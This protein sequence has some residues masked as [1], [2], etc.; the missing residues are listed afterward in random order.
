[1]AFS[2]PGGQRHIDA[3]DRTNGQLIGVDDDFG[4]S[5]AGAAKKQAEIARQG[6]EQAESGNSAAQH[7]MQIGLAQAQTAGAQ[8]AV[9]RGSNPLAQ[10]AAMY[11]SSQMANQANAQSGL[12]RAQE[13][14]NARN[15]YMGAMGQQAQGE[16]GY[17]Q[18]G[19]QQQIAQAK[20]D[21]NWQK[22]Q[23]DEEERER[24][25][26]MQM[27]GTAMSMAGMA[28]MS[29]ERT[30]NILS[31]NDGFPSELTKLEQGGRPLGSPYSDAPP[32]KKGG[33]TTGAYGSTDWA[34]FAERGQSRELP[35]N[36]FASGDVAAHTM[37]R[38]AEGQQAA[39]RGM[40][41]G[42]WSPG[43]AQE[44]YEAF[45]TPASRGAGLDAEFSG[46]GSYRV[47]D[48]VVI[49][50]PKMGR[51][52]DVGGE[53]VTPTTG[54]R[55]WAPMPA[56]SV[57][58]VGLDNAGL[59][60]STAAMAADMPEAPR[61]QIKRQNMGGIGQGFASEGATAGDMGGRGGG[62]MDAGSMAGIAGSLSDKRA[63]RLLAENQALKAQLPER[64]SS[65]TSM[66]NTPTPR[67]PERSS[68]TSEMPARHAP[69][70]P[71]GPL[72]GGQPNYSGTF[73][74]ENQWRAQHP[75]EA[76]EMDL[77]GQPAPR[78]FTGGRP[79]GQVDKA[80]VETMRAVDPLL[81]QYKPEAQRS[82]GLTS[83]PQAGPTAQNLESTPIGRHY[84]RETPAGKM[85]DTGNLT[86]ANTGMV[87]TLQKQVDEQN[88][89]IARLEAQGAPLVQTEP[90]FRMVGS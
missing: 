60:Q 19:L 35:Q 85:V 79:L 63:K 61:A 75:K 7:Q 76:A 15:Q 3:P 11:N 56:T 23:L 20:S 53:L 55:P 43:Q 88:A 41:D 37:T 33:D 73:N 42:R 59:A 18:L 40:R 83:R 90:T 82:L 51:A 70:R 72:H 52:I 36:P 2:P 78:D 54:G 62:G 30:K 24:Q 21:Q 26:G 46:T 67:G 32:Q 84:V 71:L 69:S 8:Q 57:Q 68:A 17:S 50:D 74:M 86:L 77:Y 87:S 6:L 27:M 49:N 4:G 48:Q 38:E 5:W 39:P 10:R 16:M 31:T 89:K 25:F 45:E 9:G 29:D 47:G 34:V 12:L 65:M 64:S 22:M 14:A 80:N 28:G 58:A 13:V 81:W 1:M 44:Q 66:P